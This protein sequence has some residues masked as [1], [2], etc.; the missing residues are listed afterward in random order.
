MVTVI[1]ILL[2]YRMQNIQFKFSSHKLRFKV[3]IFQATMRMFLKWHSSFPSWRK[4]YW[5]TPST[6][7]AFVSKNWLMI[8]KI[9]NRYATRLLTSAIVIIIKGLMW[10]KWKLHTMSQSKCLTS[11]DTKKPWCMMRKST[12]WAIWVERKYDWLRGD[13][14]T[15]FPVLIFW[16]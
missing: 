4:G 3:V 5:Y 6:I 14:L 9:C 8:L 13:A 7:F 12:T 15:V 16:L 10:C 2:A 11:S 1:H